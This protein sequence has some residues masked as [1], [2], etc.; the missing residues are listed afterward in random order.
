MLV[1]A[2]TIFFFRPEDDDRADHSGADS[3]HLIVDLNCIFLE[4]LLCAGS[5][6][7]LAGLQN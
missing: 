4:L 2:T 5:L 6:G 3:C 1:I 7:E